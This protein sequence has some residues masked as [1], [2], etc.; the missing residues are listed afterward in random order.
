[1]TAT[2]LPPA[3]LPHITM[4]TSTMALNHDAATPHK[5]VEGAQWW[6][7]NQRGWFLCLGCQ[8]MTHQEIERW[9]GPRL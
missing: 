1:M 8:N 3:S 2:A 7:C 6:V 9:D 4:A 5:S